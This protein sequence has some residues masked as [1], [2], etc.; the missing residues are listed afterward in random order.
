MLHPNQELTLDG[1]T[2]RYMVTIFY[3]QN[4]DDGE[5]SYKHKNRLDDARDW[6][7]TMGDDGGLCMKDLA[8]RRRTVDESGTRIRAGSTRPP[9]LPSDAYEI[10][11]RIKKDK[12]SKGG[13]S[14]SA[15]PATS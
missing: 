14:S 3:D 10:L 11:Q 4:R 13:A 1:F 8:G 12:A 7:I 6:E 15:A 5:P 2:I 9:D